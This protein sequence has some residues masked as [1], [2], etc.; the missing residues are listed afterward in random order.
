MIQ[1][2]PTYKD[3]QCYEQT[4][5]GCKDQ[6][7]VV[8]PIWYNNTV[9]VTYENTEIPRIYRELLEPG[10]INAAESV[11]MSHNHAN[12]ANHQGPHKYQSGN[13]MNFTMIV[14]PD[15]NNVRG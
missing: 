8:Y 13:E 15:E 14:R 3:N 12:N 1:N 11:Y 5:Y 4:A 7:G 2:T 9:S 6:Y 10:F